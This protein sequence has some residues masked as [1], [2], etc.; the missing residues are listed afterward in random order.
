MTVIGL[1]N[2]KRNAATSPKTVCNPRSGDIPM[3]T[4]IEK[5]KAIFLGESLML[6]IADI[7]SLR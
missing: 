2:L 6:K 7:L 3:K 4:P 1:F 5:D